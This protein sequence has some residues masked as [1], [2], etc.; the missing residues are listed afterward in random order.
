MQLAFKPSR[1]FGPEC[2]RLNAE[3]SAY[4]AEASRTNLDDQ[5]IRLYTR[6][7]DEEEIVSHLARRDRLAGVGLLR[8]KSMVGLVI[9]ALEEQRQAAVAA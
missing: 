5:V 6:G 9:L 3:A 7:W 4:L 1:P 8:L 2:Q